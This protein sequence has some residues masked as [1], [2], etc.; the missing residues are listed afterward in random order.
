MLEK[1]FGRDSE[2]SHELSEHVGRLFS[3]DQIY[4]MDHFLGY[5]M[6]QNILALRFANRIFTPAWNRENVAS[7]EIDFRE[8][9][10]VEG[11][12]KYFDD[13]GIIRDVMQ[14]HLLQM[15]SLIAMEKPKSNHTNDIR[16]FDFFLK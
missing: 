6:V 2:S 16:Y 14:N 4:R 12:G 10:G 15:M 9:L 5:E 3:E 13:A 1:P 8:N 11:R 7:I